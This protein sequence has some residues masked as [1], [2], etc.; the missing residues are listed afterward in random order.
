[1]DQ[2]GLHQDLGVVAV[3]VG[4]LRDRGRKSRDS[5]G[6]SGPLGQLQIR[7]VTQRSQRP[8]QRLTRHPPHRI[9]LQVQHRRPEPV[10]EVA[11]TVDADVEPASTTARW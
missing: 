7:V 2:C 5:S 6:V 9:R 4:D 3:E 8:A 1:M 11:Q 10:P